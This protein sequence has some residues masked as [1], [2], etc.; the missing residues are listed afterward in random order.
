MSRAFIACR[1][2]IIRRRALRSEDSIMVSFLVHP[3]MAHD[4]G[5]LSN[6]VRTTSF[7]SVRAKTSMVK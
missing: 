7:E 4:D 3:S 2:N 6:R 5:M 1:I